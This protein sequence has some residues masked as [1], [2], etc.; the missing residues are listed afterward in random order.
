VWHD[1]GSLAEQ[2]LQEL[3]A[4]ASVRRSLPPKP[5]RRAMLRLIVGRTLVRWGERLARPV[6]SPAAH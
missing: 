3:Y 6:G 1:Y 5:R 2:R 4:D